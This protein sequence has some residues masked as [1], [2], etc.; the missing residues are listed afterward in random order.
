MSDFFFYVIFWFKNHVWRFFVHI[1]SQHLFL[2]CRFLKLRWMWLY[3]ESKRL[4]HFPILFSEE[5]LRNRHR[6]DEHKS[7][8]G[9]QTTQNQIAVHFH[10]CKVYCCVH[11]CDLL[12]P[13]RW[14]RHGILRNELEA[15][16]VHKQTF[17]YGCH[18]F[19]CCYRRTFERGSRL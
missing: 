10:L 7:G 17:Y 16:V 2:T 1:F 3:P 13:S 4:T 12:V 6:V 18:S 9:P 8:E 19:R 5:L 14:P 11:Q 15:P